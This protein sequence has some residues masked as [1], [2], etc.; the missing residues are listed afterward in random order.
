MHKGFRIL[1]LAV[2][3][4]C[5]L[6]SKGSIASNEDSV[7]VTYHEN[8]KTK[9][10]GSYRNGE[11]HGRWKTYNEK[12]HKIKEARY[13]MGKMRWERIYKDGKLI[14]TTDHKGRIRKMS[15]CGC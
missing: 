15:D 11:K 5:T 6:P 8:G 3:L 1:F 10:K 2:L 12:G 14:Q 4:V 7:V 13:K 9:E